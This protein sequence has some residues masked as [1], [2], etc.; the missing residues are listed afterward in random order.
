ML[1]EYSPYS[2]GYLMWT[3]I[4]AKAAR[5]MLGKSAT[6]YPSQQAY[7]NALHQEPD[8]AKA[9]TI[10]HKIRATHN[11]FSF[12]QQYLSTEVHEKVLKL[13][14][15]KQQIEQ[16]EATHIGQRSP[17]RDL[18]TF[19]TMLLNEASNFGQPRIE[20]INGDYQ[21]KGEL[22]LRHTNTEFGALDPNYLNKVLP[23]LREFWGRPVH[24][25]TV[26][27]EAGKEDLVK[28]VCDGT[29]VKSEPYVDSK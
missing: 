1:S 16:F 24:L 22:L 3:D 8:D 28:L 29:E 7:V 20:V 11:D 2:L 17:L 10:M 26:T 13:H 9:L 27:P 14:P 12:I 23:I 5:G 15:F 6:D 19:K 21:N 18:A 4:Y 25:I